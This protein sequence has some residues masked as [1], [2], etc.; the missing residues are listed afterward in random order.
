M[1]EVTDGYS[2]KKLNPHQQN[3]KGKKFTVRSLIQKSAKLNKCGKFQKSFYGD[4]VLSNNNT[5]SFDELLQEK[6]GSI[7]RLQRSKEDEEAEPEILSTQY[8]ESTTNVW[9]SP[10]INNLNSMNNVTE[11]AYELYSKLQTQKRR[12]KRSMRDKLEQISNLEDTCTPN[13]CQNIVVKGRL[14]QSTKKQ[15]SVNLYHLIGEDG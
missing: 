10:F 13:D 3:F 15:V 2:S 1:L 7:S 4:E 11:N 12:K 5:K 8:Q 9:K 14:R 6:K